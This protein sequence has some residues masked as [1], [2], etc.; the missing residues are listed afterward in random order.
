MK[1]QKKEEMVMPLYG[2][3]VVNRATHLRAYSVILLLDN[4]LIVHRM[5]FVCS[6]CRFHVSEPLKSC[7]PETARIATPLFRIDLAAAL[8]INNIIYWVYDPAR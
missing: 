6:C 7:G 3:H 1:R 2:D 8:L 4:I 5:Q